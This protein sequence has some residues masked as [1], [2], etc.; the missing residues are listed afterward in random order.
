MSCS[1]FIE[2][3]DEDKSDTLVVIVNGDGTVSVDR[4][5]LERVL[6]KSFYSY[7]KLLCFS[8]LL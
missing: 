3:D 2:H 1:Q 8:L 4:E 7:D 6:R 5:T